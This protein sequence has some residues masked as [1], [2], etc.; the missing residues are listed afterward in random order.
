MLSFVVTAATTSQILHT[1]RQ[2]DRNGGFVTPG[3]CLSNT[4]TVIKDG[5]TSTG[6]D[7]G[8]SRTASSYVFPDWDAS[9]GDVEAHME[10][11]FQ[12]TC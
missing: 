1:S 10:G 4:V 12:W 8:S 7:D 5:E 3:R 11:R 9:S 6:S 2:S